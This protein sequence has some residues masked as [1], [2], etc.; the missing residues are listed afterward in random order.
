M[1][2]D[3]ALV[4]AATEFAT[5]LTTTVQAAF[6]ERVPPF[7][8][9]TRGVRGT[10]RGAVAIR[11]E[12]S[13]GIELLIARVP[14]VRL[15]V[16][17]RCSWDHRQAYLAVEKSRINVLATGVTEPLFR[18]DYVRTP[19]GMIPSAHVQ[20]HAH[21]DAITALMVRAGA[22][23]RRARTRRT[24]ATAGAVPAVSELHLTVGG[25]RFRPCLEDLLTMLIDELGVDAQPGAH[26]ALDSGREQ[27]RRLQLSAAVRDSP[28]TA[29][30][31]LRELG[32]TVTSPSDG[33]PPERVDKL[34]AL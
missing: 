16:S 13:E 4:T 19:Q 26:S 2:E 7:H 25:P 22:S 29:A 14:A 31:V 27:W 9:Q 5:T 30:R 23:S 15:K 32:Y 17:Y 6:G 11:Q 28:T 21:R 18:Y 34:R 10:G 1:S 24:S 8:A 20:V 3:A 12:P 33:E